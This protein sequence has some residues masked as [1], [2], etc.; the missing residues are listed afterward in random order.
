MGVWAV[1]GYRREMGG[2]ARL[3]VNLPY[4]SNLQSFFAIDRSGPGDPGEVKILFSGEISRRKGVDLL[5]QAFRDFVEEGR[6][7]GSRFSAQERSSASEARARAGG[8][9][10]GVPRLQAMERTSRRLR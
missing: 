3:Y 8:G 9:A 2:D 4:C 6:P 5:A 10:R 7:R 1:E